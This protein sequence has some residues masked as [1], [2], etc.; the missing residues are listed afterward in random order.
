MYLY[1]TYV[2]YFILI[3]KSLA[4]II[5]DSA[6]PPLLSY[7][8][9]VWMKTPEKAGRA[10]GKGGRGG[11]KGL[12]V[13][14]FSLYLSAYKNDLIYTVSLIFRKI[15]PFLPNSLFSL[16]SSQSFTRPPTYS[17]APANQPVKRRRE[18]G[19]DFLLDPLQSLPPDQKKGEK[20]N[21]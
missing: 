17:A 21:F 7:V 2:F 4:V 6:P 14:A 5:C 9:Y 20:N 12:S 19:V 10:G 15:S 18:K 1:C 13:C 16:L 8:T 11:K 3:S